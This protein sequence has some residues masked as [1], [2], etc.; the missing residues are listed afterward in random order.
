MS[1]DSKMGNV[2]VVVKKG[3]GLLPALPTQKDKQKLQDHIF[4]E[5]NIPHLG[6]P[7]ITIPTAGITLQGP[8]LIQVSKMLTEDIPLELV[9]DTQ[10]KP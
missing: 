4:Q 8:L 1:K 9:K 2:W 3:T 6:Y 5:V 10:A 7:D